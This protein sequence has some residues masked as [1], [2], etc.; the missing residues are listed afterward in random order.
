ME[1][2]CKTERGKRC[3]NKEIE[4]LSQEQKKLRL[5]IEANTD[6][7]EKVKLK[8]RRNK[9]INQIPNLARKEEVDKIN[10]KSEEIE[11]CKNDTN[12]TYQVIRQLQ[13]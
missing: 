7:S 11:K 12:E 4:A 13:P 1:T 6:E 8:E 3:D 10:E 5:D 2:I 9:L